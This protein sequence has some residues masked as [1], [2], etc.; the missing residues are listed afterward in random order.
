MGITV[1]Y[2]LQVIAPKVVARDGKVVPEDRLPVVIFGAVL[3]A[4]GLF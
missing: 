1:W 2:T 3:F 4:T